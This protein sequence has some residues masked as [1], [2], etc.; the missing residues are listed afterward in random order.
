MSNVLDLERGDSIFYIS[1]GEDGE[2]AL[3]DEVYKDKSVAVARAQYLKT[4]ERN[5][6]IEFWIVEAEIIGVFEVE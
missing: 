5:P 2:I 4:K 3:T 6:G 1:T